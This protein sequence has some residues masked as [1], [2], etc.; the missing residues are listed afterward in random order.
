MQH[1][2]SAAVLQISTR[3]K[4]VSFSLLS[5]HDPSACRLMCHMDNYDLCLI[6]NSGSYVLAL[7]TTMW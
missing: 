1:R 2:S 6:S 3:S 4:V 7:Q 5:V